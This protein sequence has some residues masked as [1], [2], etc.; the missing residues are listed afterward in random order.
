MPQKQVIDPKYYKELNKQNGTFGIWF[1]IPRSQESANFFCIGSD[2]KYFRIC[3][4][5]LGHDLFA[6]SCSKL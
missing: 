5:L 1:T 2:S 6:D 3:G 4:H